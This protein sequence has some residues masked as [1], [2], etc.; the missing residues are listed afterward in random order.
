MRRARSAKAAT[1]SASSAGAPNS[2]RTQIETTGAMS[3]SELP[4]VQLVVSTTADR[5]AT[6]P[7]PHAVSPPTSRLPTR[8]VR[9]V[10]AARTAWATHA[11]TAIARTT[12]GE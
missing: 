2:S 1:S 10:R 7:M 5:A 4:T 9:S 8:T 11:A 6:P 12:T 3:S